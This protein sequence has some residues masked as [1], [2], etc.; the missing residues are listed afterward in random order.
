MPTRKTKV[1]PANQFIEDNVAAIAAAV[2]V[3][4][5]DKKGGNGQG[6]R[7]TV[8]IDSDLHEKLRAH[9]YHNRQS[10]VATVSAALEQY[11]EG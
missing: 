10:M 1:K 9:C 6:H 7:L 8:R 5:P 2:D 3:V 4:D 11:L